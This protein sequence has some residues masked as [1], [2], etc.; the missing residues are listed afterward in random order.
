MQMGRVF[1]NLFT[2]SVKYNDNQKV[3]IKIYVKKINDNFVQ[4]VFTDNG[5]GVPQESLES[6][7][8]NF[9]RVDESRNNAVEGN[10]LGL[11]ICKNI[12]EAH[13]GKISAQCEKSLEI[14]ITLPIG[15]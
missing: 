6:L 4:I 11:A 12:V 10:G 3:R 13:K 14:I 8:D 2:N 9:Y 7:F 1:E 15:E 5:I